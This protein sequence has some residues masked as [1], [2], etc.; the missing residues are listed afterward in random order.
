MSNGYNEK[1]MKAVS[2]LQNGIVA[3]KSAEDGIKMRAIQCPDMKVPDA[4]VNTTP[5]NTVGRVGYQKGGSEFTFD[6]TLTKEPQD[7]DLHNFN[8]TWT[9]KH[10]GHYLLTRYC[11]SSTLAFG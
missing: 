5:S 11:V 10:I 2:S 6:A 1:F 8:C 7:N 3:T 9:S 4:D